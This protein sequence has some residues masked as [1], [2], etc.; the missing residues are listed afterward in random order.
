MWRQSGSHRRGARSTYIG[1]AIPILAQE[2]NALDFL[3]QA[4]PIWHQTTILNGEAGALDMMG[5][6]YSD[7][8][9][10]PKSLELS[11]RLCLSGVKSES[12]PARL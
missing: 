8:S 3:N 6:V 1:R 4:M 2:D 12:A 5:K 11:T 10:G 7:M 9:Q